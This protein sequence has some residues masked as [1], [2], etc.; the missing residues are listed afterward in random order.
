[1]VGAAFAC[2]VTGAVSWWGGY[3]RRSWDWSSY[4]RWWVISQGKER[5][6]ERGVE[7][8]ATSPYQEGHVPGLG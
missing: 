6:E 5:G 4:R 8:E 7:R 2:G 3:L 1:V